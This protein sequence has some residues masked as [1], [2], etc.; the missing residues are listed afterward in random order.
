MEL[1][2]SILLQCICSVLWMLA[3]GIQVNVSWYV[4]YLYH[5]FFWEEVCRICLIEIVY[6]QR[7]LNNPYLQNPPLHF[8]CVQQ[9]HKHHKIECW[10]LSHVILLTIFLTLANERWSS[11]VAESL[12]IYSSEC[13]SKGFFFSLRSNSKIEMKSYRLRGH[14]AISAVNRSEN[15]PIFTKIFTH[16]MNVEK[17]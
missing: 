9:Q 4:K 2:N 16:S 17:S 13:I 10:K 7:H 6:E 11:N 1:S 5:C 12:W 3:K 8:G 15:A 14:R